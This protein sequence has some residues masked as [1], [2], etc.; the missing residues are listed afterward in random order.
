MPEERAAR[1]WERHTVAISIGVSFL[2]DGQQCK[3]NAQASDVSK[4]GLA[5]FTTREIA[6]GVCLRLE[7]KLPYSSTPLVIQSVVRTRSG[8]NYGIEFVN[9]TPDH[10]EIIERTCRV[11]SLLS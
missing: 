1:R 7:F 3:F 5:L 4:G 9:P 6:I 8:F 11:F 2:A 10:Q